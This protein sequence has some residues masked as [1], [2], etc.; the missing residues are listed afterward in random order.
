M[1]LPVM[2]T[3]RDFTEV[4]GVVIDPKHYYRQKVAMRYQLGRG[5]VPDGARS[6]PGW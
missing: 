1:K 4:T 2:A 5:F 6:N 3:L